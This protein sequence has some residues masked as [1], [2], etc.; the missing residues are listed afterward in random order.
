MLAIDLIS[1][2][3]PSLQTSDTGQMALNYMEV[4]R[5]S[6]LPIVNNSQLLG[7]I[8]DSDIFDMNKAD[9]PI[10]NHSLSLFSPYVYHHQHIYDVTEIVARL[11]LTVVPVL[12]DKD[13]YIGLIS[14]HDLLQGL[15]KVTAIEKRGAIIVLEINQHDYSLSQ[16]SQIVE[17]N[18][19]KILSLYLSDTNESMKM[20]V[21]L[22]INTSDINSIIQTF[23]RYNYIILG[24]WGNNS[25]IDTL[26]EERFDAFMR[27][28]NT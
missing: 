11:K 16:I 23:N 18:N 7:L 9:E 6:H 5:V 24:S 20:N 22:K 28:L 12:S 2:V 25:D 21:T 27:Y 13:D 3:I 4:F 26:Y 8:S 14:L 19:A 17:S 10:G 1:D 15:A